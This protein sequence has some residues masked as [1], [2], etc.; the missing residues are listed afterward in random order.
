ME[1]I[2]HL[3][4]DTNHVSIRLIE[5]DRSVIEKTITLKNFSDLFKQEERKTYIMPHKLFWDYET[6]SVIPGMIYG[7]TEGSNCKG[8]FFIPASKRY[9]DVSGE[10]AIMPYPSV[11]FSLNTVRGRLTDSKCYAVKEN[12]L[13]E[14]NMG[15]RLYAFPFGNVLYSDAHICWGQNKMIDLYEYNDLRSAITV[16]FSA[17]SNKDYINPG[18]SY[19]AKY[20]TYENFLAELKKLES[21]PEDALVESPYMKSLGELVEIFSKGEF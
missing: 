4:S 16:F 15:S 18:K 2:I 14:L 10:K 6:V 11:V 3:K 13:N 9:M 17:E 5:D 1:Q 7:E 21:F 19:S 8:I 12:D 20:G